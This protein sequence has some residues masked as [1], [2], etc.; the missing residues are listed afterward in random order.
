[1]L[2][3]TARKIPE[4][5]IETPDYEVDG[6]VEPYLVEVKSRL[7][8]PAVLQPRD[9]GGPTERSMTRDIKVFAWLKKASQ[10]MHAYEPPHRRLWF[11][12]CSAESS[13][14]SEAQRSRIVD[15]LC[16][17][18]GFCT[19][20]PLP[21]R[22]FTAYS[23]ARSPFETFTEIDGAVVYD[24]AGGDLSFV[25]NEYSPRLQRVLATKLL[26]HLRGAGLSSILVRERCGPG[27]IVV[28]PQERETDERL[29]AYLS[30]VK[31]GP[32]GPFE[33]KEYISRPFVV[34][35]VPPEDGK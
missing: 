23:A 1:V 31:G 10:Q 27:D 33:M 30:G 13:I 24:P 22:H 6:D 19:K 15:Q 2:G 16:G 5:A 21:F 25:P 7:L 9:G 35:D 28:P 3:L 11:V 14:A 34:G 17:A 4:T 12:W 32:V 26:G 8:D 18:R 29:L 20:P